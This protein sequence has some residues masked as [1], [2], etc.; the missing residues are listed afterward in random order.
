MVPEVSGD[1]GGKKACPSSVGVLLSPLKSKLH[2]LTTWVSVV[3]T[4][5]AAVAQ[6]GFRRGGRTALQRAILVQSRPVAAQISKA[7]AEQLPAVTWMN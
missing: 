3:C 4:T 5:E 6:P 1:P 2:V 7:P